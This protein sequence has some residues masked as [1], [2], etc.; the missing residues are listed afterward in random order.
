MKQ[1]LFDWLLLLLRWL[2]IMVGI[3]W[4][5]ASIFFMWLDRTF[6][7]GHLW[8]IHGGG[9][10]HVQKHLMGTTKAPDDLHWFK[11][12]SYWTWMSGMLLLALIFY[13]SGGTFL[14]DKSVADI[15]FERGILIGSGAIIVSWFFYDLLWESA[16]TKKL[17]VAGHIF[18][19][20]WFGGISF[21][22]CRYLSGRAAYIHLGAILGTWMAG[23]VF[24]RI[25]PRQV[26]MVE[27]AKRNEKVNP[28]WA[29]NAKSRSTHNTYFT[30]PVIFIMLSNHFP[31]TYGSDKNW[32]I[33]L[34]ISAAGASIRE[35]FVVR[36]QNPPRSY[37]FAG[38]GAL[39]I[40]GLVFMSRD[41]SGQIDLA[42]TPGGAVAAVKQEAGIRGVV[43]FIGEIPARKTINLPPGCG[44]SAVLDNDVLIQNGRLQNVFVA[45]TKGLPTRDFGA[46]P[47]IPVLVDQRDC[48]YEPR[49][50]AV[51]VGQP[52]EFVNSD[53]VF[54]NVRT[55]AEKNE[56]FN[57]GMPNKND[58]LVR[59]FDKAEILLQTK[60]SVHP[61]MGAYIA[62]SDHP[63][64]GLS[65]QIGEF[66]I[67][68]LPA[69][70]YTLEA[71]HEVFG[72]MSQEIS[73]KDGEILN[74]EFVYRG[75][76]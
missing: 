66:E 27:A 22:L 38:I 19:L 3:S 47:S 42:K 13:T 52:V 37:A 68:R 55:I 49:V 56:N 75:K 29:K 62:V 18:T 60:C 74:V 6:K 48:I 20:L 45:I 14:I 57:I 9:F 36:R 72:K 63:F 39:I 58:R 54:H 15:S 40:S 46:A 41:N 50:T 4:I 51:R 7:D 16:L 8:M 73:V 30:L 32:L 64:F 2:H 34:F 65:N 44:K 1:D 69:G 11:W 76:K 33:L 71:W 23:N 25:I 5:G 61:W 21:L 53:A 26:K 67:P 17:P 12:E 10:Y 70:H 43:K 35:Y 28:E 59:V 24:L 31:S